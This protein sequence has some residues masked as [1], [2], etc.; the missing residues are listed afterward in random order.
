MTIST[1]RKEA[2]ITITCRVNLDDIAGWGHNPE[3]W[4]RMITN[5]IEKKKSLMKEA[6]EIMEKNPQYDEET[7]TNNWQHITDHSGLEPFLRQSHYGAEVIGVS[8]SS[9]DNP[10]WLAKMEKFNKDWNK[11][12]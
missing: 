12:E 4:V 9:R 6:N 7:K 2:I 5:G 1:S 10:S 11:D 8:A 3:D